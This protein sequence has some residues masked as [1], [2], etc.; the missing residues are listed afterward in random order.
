MCDEFFDENRNHSQ[1]R[2]FSRR[3][4]GILPIAHDIPKK[5][6]SVLADSSENRLPETRAVTQ[7][8]MTETD[9]D[10]NIE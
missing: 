4:R 5:R 7:S 6:L 10:E 9:C 8:K 1:N 2:N 3:W